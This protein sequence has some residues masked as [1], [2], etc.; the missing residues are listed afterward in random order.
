MYALLWLIG[1]LAVILGAPSADA[2]SGLDPLGNPHSESGSV[3]DP[4]G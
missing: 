3:W 1:S 2:G 4:N